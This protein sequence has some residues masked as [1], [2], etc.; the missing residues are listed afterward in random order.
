MIVDS[1]WLLCSES[2]NFCGE[3]RLLWLDF[4]LWPCYE[5]KSLCMAWVGGN[6]SRVMA[7][8]S[9]WIWDDPA[10]QNWWEWIFQQQPRISLLLCHIQELISSTSVQ[11]S[12]SPLTKQSSLRER[13][14]IP[15]KIT[16]ISHCALVSFGC[17]YLVDPSLEAIG[18]EQCIYQLRATDVSSC[19]E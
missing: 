16:E 10:L 13:C 12:R 4:C 8:G 11:G 17:F 3:W 9:S 1:S 2:F 15:L 19:A 18:F 6:L 14:V 7:L 5:Q